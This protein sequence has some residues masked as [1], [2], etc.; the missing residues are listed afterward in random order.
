MAQRLR[1]V[2]VMSGEVNQFAIE[3]INCPHART[4]KAYGA[5]CDRVEHWLQVGW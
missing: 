4:A 2:V 3:S 5:G 1:W